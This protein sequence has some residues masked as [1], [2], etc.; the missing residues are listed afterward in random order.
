MKRFLLMRVLGM[1]VVL[2]T[3]TAV[4]F[5]LRQ[6]VPSDPAR[7]AVGPNAPASAVEAKRV[8]L[9]LDEP[10][11]RQYVDYLGQLIHLDLGES[12]RTRQPV[13]SDISNTLPASLELAAAALLLAL[14][15]GPGIALLQSIL[16]RPGPLNYVLA[17]ANSAPIFLTGL[18][19][20]YVLWFRF[21]IFPGGGRTSVSDVPTG[22]TGFHTLDALLAGRWF[23]A[24]DAT[25][26]LFLP[27]LTLALPMAAAVGRSLRSSLIGVLREDYVRTARSKGIPERYILRRH[28]IR[29]ASTAPLAMA[30]LQVGFLFANLLVVERIFAWP[31][32]GAYTIQALTVSDL[33]AVLGASLVFGAMYIIVN[34]IVDLGQAW[35]DPRVTLE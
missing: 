31:G 28:G 9:G 7:A 6:V 12:V 14:L 30:G 20:L 35:L 1:M 24:W 5:M 32:L 11:M 34:T 19:L 18:L 17:T 21:H 25:Q 23:V 13:R 2:V 3:M 29:N 26:H 33:T 8:E 4:I 16:P 10:V 15:I 27:A 22:P